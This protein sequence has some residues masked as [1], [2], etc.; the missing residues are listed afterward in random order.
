MFDVGSTM[1][2]DNDCII[3]KNT[4]PKSGMKTSKRFM[5]TAKV[6]TAVVEALFS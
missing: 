4:T 3:Q 2:G 6:K 1:I 5:S